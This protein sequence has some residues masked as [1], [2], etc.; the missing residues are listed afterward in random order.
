MRRNTQSGNV[1]SSHS[2][3]CGASSLVAKFVIDSRSCSCSSLKMKCLRLAWKSGFKTL[4]AV[5]AN[6]A[7]FGVDAP[8]VPRHF[9]SESFVALFKLIGDLGKPTLCATRGHTL[10]AALGIALA[11]D[12]FVASQEATFGTPEINVGAFPFMI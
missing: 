4:S 1:V 12:L 10:A 2:S 11:C 9:G 7:G 5:A 8:L 3:A 6:C